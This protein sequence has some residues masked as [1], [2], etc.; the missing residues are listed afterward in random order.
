MG[1]YIFFFFEKFTFDP[2]ELPFMVGQ[3]SLFLG[4][5][6]LTFILFIILIILERIADRS[7]TKKF[8]INSFA[9]G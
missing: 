4:E 9:L 7:I 8:R 6:A 5:C 3:N 1:F 2:A